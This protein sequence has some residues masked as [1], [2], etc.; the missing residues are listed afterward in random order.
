MI[1]FGF[2]VSDLCGKQVKKLAGLM[3]REPADIVERAV[4]E[5]FRAHGSEDEWQAGR[6][7]YRR[8]VKGGR[9]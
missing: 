5:Y 2:N 7:E 8:W 6:A 4:S 1:R 9:K 3:H